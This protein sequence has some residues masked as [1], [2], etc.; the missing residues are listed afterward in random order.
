MDFYFGNGR[1]NGVVDKGEEFE[2]GILVV[3]GVYDYIGG[4][5][6]GLFIKKVVWYGGFVYDVWFNVVLV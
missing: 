4:Y 6:W 1:S 2:N 5:G 3:D